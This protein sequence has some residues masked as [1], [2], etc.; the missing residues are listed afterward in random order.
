MILTEDHTSSCTWLFV[1]EREPTPLGRTKNLSEGAAAPDNKKGIA[2]DAWV[3]PNALIAVNQPVNSRAAFFKMSSPVFLKETEVPEV[4]TLNYT[5]KTI[6]VKFY[7]EKFL[8]V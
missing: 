1:K 5:N 8:P 7:F 2:R 4:V 3:F 6:G